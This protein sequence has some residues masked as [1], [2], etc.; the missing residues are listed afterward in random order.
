MGLFT[1]V[2]ITD[3]R[4]KVRRIRDGGGWFALAIAA[5]SALGTFSG[6]QK[7]INIAEFAEEYGD[8]EPELRIEAILDV[9]DPLNSIVRVDRTILVI[10]TTIFNGQDDDGDW[11]REVDDVGEDGI[12]ASDMP[13]IGQ[14]EGEGNGRPDPGEPHVDELDEVLS[15]IHDATVTVILWDSTANSIILDFAWNPEADSF[16]VA[17]GPPMGFNHGPGEERLEVVT[18]GAYKPTAVYDTIAIDHKYEFRITTRITTD[19]DERLITGTVYP[20]PPPVFDID[21]Q[22]LIGDTL[23]VE[24]GGPGQLIWTT[25]QDATVYWVLIEE[26]LGPDSLRTMISHPSAPVEQRDDGSWI[27]QEP[28]S[29]FPPGLYRWTVSVPSRAYGAYVFSQLPMRDEQV[30]NLRDENG[31]VVLGIA[32][33]TASASQYVR[34]L[35]F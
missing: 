13:G 8:Y 31:E 25:V 7:D 10:D 16:T 17:G 28:L 26:V 5:L 34:I 27:G 21:P 11:D 23:Q 35:G 1:M 15:Q 24:L 20:L 14:D 12:R 2:F 33:S 32:G 4:K 19:E 30:S 3:N 29:M 9:V 6:C 18:Y 22:D